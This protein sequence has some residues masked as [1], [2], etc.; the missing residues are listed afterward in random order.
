MNRLNMK[1]AFIV[2]VLGMLAGAWES[3]AQGTFQNLDFESAQVIF[4][5]PPFNHQIDATNALPGWEAFSGTTQLDSIP[6]NI[7]AISTPVSLYSNY[8]GGSVEGFFS[9][10]FGVGGSI[11]QSGTVPAD[12]QSLLFKV[13]NWY[14]G[15]VSIDGQ[16]LSYTVVSNTANYTYLFG[17]DVSSFAGQTVTLSF[18]QMGELDDIEFSPSAIPEPS[19][20]ILLGLSTLLFAARRFRGRRGPP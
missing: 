1:R 18:T 9:V 20:A 17:A 6:Y 2:F 5:D 16:S 14:G 3:I 13:F 7:G 15:I 19:A 4:N 12:A 8:G 11:S 10:Q